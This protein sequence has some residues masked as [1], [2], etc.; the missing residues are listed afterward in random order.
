MDYLYH[1]VPKNMSGTILYPLNILKKIKPDIYA[2][3]A[4]K[5]DGRE[6]LLEV[7]ILPLKCL[8]NDVLH[9]T[10]VSPTELKTNLAKA[11]IE[12]DPI[13]FYKIP[14]SMIEGEGSIAFIYRRDVVLQPSFKEY[15]PFNPDRMSF[16]RQ[17][18]RKTIEYY[19]EKHTEG[20]RPLLFHLVPHILYKGNVETKG[21]EIVTA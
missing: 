1:R 3:Q 6:Q 20:I 8:W 9:F 14:A 2:E 10:A 19:K 5:Y 16:Y 15:E 11:G 4:K 13:S 18:P 17:V 21:L 12:I 7:E